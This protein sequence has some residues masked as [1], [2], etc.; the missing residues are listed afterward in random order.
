MPRAPLHQSIWIYN[1]KIRIAYFCKVCLNTG[2]YIPSSSSRNLPSKQVVTDTQT[3]CMFNES[4][5]EFSPD[6]NVNYHK[7]LKISL[8]KH[9][10]IEIFICT[11][12]LKFWNARVSS[13]DEVDQASDL[14]SL[15]DKTLVY[16]EAML[17]THWS[18]VLLALTH[19]YVAMTSQ[20]VHPS[21]IFFE[22]C[23]FLLVTLSTISMMN[24][25]L[26][27]ECFEATIRR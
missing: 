5:Y 4:G 3:M 14:R 22:A 19:R 11:Y 13:G 10:N 1:K 15:Y 26:V 20:A 2:N 9:K 12:V 7:M 23:S 16:T 27:Y 8:A 21:G 17:L 25:I 24:S 6:L 18:Y